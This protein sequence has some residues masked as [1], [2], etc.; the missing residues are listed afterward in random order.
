MF[1]DC[2]ITYKDKNLFLHGY[3]DEVEKAKHEFVLIVNHVLKNL[4]VKYGEQIHSSKEIQW[5]YETDEKIWKSFSVYINDLIE[6]SY[7]NSEANVHILLLLFIW[8]YFSY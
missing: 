6:T 8:N 4:L 3:K 7:E 1:Q 2:D 5:Q